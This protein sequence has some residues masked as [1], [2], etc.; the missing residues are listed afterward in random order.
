MDSRLQSLLPT[1]HAHHLRLSR[2]TGEDDVEAPFRALVAEDYW[3]IQGDD[4]GQVRRGEASMVAG[5]GSVIAHRGKD[6]S[7]WVGG[8]DA[9]SIA[10]GT[11][12]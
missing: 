1:W 10:G 8:R 4:E 6:L 3:L 7:P 11:H 9:E 2:K 12:A 5:A